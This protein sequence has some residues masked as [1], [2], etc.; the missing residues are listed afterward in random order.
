VATQKVREVI[1]ILDWFAVYNDACDQIDHYEA[2]REQAHKIIDHY[3]GD[4]IHGD[5]GGHRYA[6]RANETHTTIDY[7]MARALLKDRDLL[8][9]VTTTSTRRELIIYRTPR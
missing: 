9:L 4:A 3:M 6:T 7:V 5:V 8:D 2:R 1:P